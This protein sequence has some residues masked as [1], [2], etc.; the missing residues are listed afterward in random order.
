MRVDGSFGLQNLI[1]AN[2][3][4]ILGRLGI[5][6]GIRAQILDFTASEVLLKLMDGTTFTAASMVPLDAKKGD[7]VDFVVKNKTKGQIFLEIVNSGSIKSKDIDS[8][9]EKMLVSM[10]IRPDENNKEIAREIRNADLSL[11]KEVFERIKDLVARFKDLNP[12][13]A[14]FLLANGLEPQEGNIAFLNRLVENKFKIASKLDEL[15]NSLAETGDTV[16]LDRLQNELDLLGDGKSMKMRDENIQG[17]NQ[18]TGKKLAETKKMTAN[19]TTNL[20]AEIPEKQVNLTADDGTRGHVPELDTQDAGTP[21]DT[22]KVLGTVKAGTGLPDQDISG[23]G[24]TPLSMA[25][26]QF[27]GEHTQRLKNSN[28]SLFEDGSAQLGKNAAIG[29]AEYKQALKK[30]FDKVFLKVD[31]ENFDK[32][33][34][35]KNSYRQT[36]ERLE[37]IK[38]S[39]RTSSLSN[40]EDLL[41]K[42]DE[43]HSSIKFMNGINNHAVYIQLP[44]NIQGNHTTGEL[45]VLKRD[46]TKKKIDPGNVTIFLSLNTHNLGRIDSLLHINKKNISINL[47]VEDKSIF[48]LLKSNYKVLYDGLEKIGYKLVDLKYKVIEEDVNILNITKIAQENWA[49]KT[50]ID[51]RI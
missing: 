48:D 19:V 17:P 25:V 3:A 44:L 47:R 49:G 35:I 9:M 43:L 30:V 28:L 38:D 32:S 36:L 5:G 2:I 8:E 33:I 39:I 23:S 27:R 26:S 41:N 29:E 50:S 45:Y 21:A 34:H 12:S 15:V 42:I 40:R 10:D 1:A 20:E 4:D 18:A 37:I 46:S 7:F 13:K 22:K 11:S 31:E 16:V 24:D 51:Y 14:A 6:D